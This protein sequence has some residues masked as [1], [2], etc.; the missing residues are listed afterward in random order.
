[1]AIGTELDDGPG[2]YDRAITE[3][4]NVEALGSANRVATLHFDFARAL[5]QAHGRRD[6]EAIRHLDRADRIAPVLIRNDPAPNTMPG[7]STACATASVS[8]RATT[9]GA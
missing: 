4:I 6:D 3:P 2:A 7:N 1:M 5:A 8:H 9:P